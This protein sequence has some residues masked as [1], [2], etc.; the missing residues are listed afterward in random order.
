MGHRSRLSV[1]VWAVSAIENLKSANQIRP[2]QL[3]LGAGYVHNLGLRD[4]QLFD[5]AFN[6]LIHRLLYKLGSLA[7]I[8]L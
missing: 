4:A 5:K 1:S 2:G 3:T 6:L 8:A 7:Q